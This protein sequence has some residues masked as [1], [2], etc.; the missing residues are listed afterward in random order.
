[1]SV[2]LGTDFLLLAGFDPL[3]GT[4]TGPRLV[5]AAVYRR[6]TTDPASAAG[7]RIYN[8]E[9]CD[10]SQLLGSRGNAATDRAWE[11]RLVRTAKVDD[12]VDDCTAT[13]TRSDSGK[14]V[15]LRELITVSGQQ[16]ELVIAFPDLTPEILDG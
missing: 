3:F 13:L 1:M 12:R 14:V 7:V 8:G 4:V 15:S 5:V 2:G 10:L 6:H 16:Q 9:C 11:Q